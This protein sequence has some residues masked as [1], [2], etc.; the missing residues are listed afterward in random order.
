MPKYNVRIYGRSKPRGLPEVGQMPPALSTAPDWSSKAREDANTPFR[1]PKL[2]ES[3]DKSQGTE[4]ISSYQHME[5]LTPSPDLLPYR[6][7]SLRGDYLHMSGSPLKVPV[8]ASFD[9]PRLKHALIAPKTAVRFSRSGRPNMPRNYESIVP[10][11]SATLVRPQTA[12][13]DTKSIRWALGTAQSVNFDQ[14][15][16][17]RHQGPFSREFTRKCMAPSNWV[18]M[19]YGRTHSIM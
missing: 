17:S 19:K 12:L 10:S 15:G 9:Y 4:S 16:R 13:S 3:A 18:K 11:K 8:K 7:Q 1:L 2:Y 14:T 5:F 6:I